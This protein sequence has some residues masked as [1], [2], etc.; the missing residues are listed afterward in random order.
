MKKKHIEVQHHHIW[1][2]ITDKRLEIGKADT[3]LNIVDS[4]RKPLP[5]DRF[6]ILTGH[7]ELQWS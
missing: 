5:E 4:L 2:L 3:E 1:K 6:K 7:I